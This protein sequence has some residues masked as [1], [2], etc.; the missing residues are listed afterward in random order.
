MQQSTRSAPRRITSA[1]A[2]FGL[3]L[4]TETSPDPQASLTR[5]IED[6]ADTGQQQT[7]QQVTVVDSDGDQPW[8]DMQQ[9]PDAAR[10]AEPAQNA[11]EDESD[12]EQAELQSPISHGRRRAAVIDSDDESSPEDGKLTV[13]M[14]ASQDLIANEMQQESAAVNRSPQ[15]LSRLRK[16][17]PAEADGSSRAQQS[18]SKRQATLSVADRLAAHQQAH[19]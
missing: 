13:V 14:D 16:D 12:A 3:R 10:T 17:P 11:Q 15:R 7:V 18:A 9:Q 2:Q 1:A 5:E 19:R 6:H 4:A 8:V